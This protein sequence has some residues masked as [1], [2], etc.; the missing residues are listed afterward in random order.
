MEL[1]KDTIEVIKDTYLAAQ[2][3]FFIGNG[4]SSLSNT[5]MRLKDWPETNIK[6]LY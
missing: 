5:V 6:L 4:Y 2:C 1:I 3:D